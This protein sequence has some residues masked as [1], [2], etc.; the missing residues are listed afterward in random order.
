MKI[1]ILVLTINSVVI[2]QSLI[3]PSLSA[4]KINDIHFVNDNEIILINSG[5]SIYKSYNGGNSWELKSHFQGESLI[6]IEF[7]NENTGFILP[8]K[9]PNIEAIGI[10]YTADAGDNWE[11]QPLDVSGIYDFIPLSESVSLKST[12]NGQIERLN[13]F[14]NKWD[15]VYSLP[16]F[17]VEDPEFGEYKV[18]YGEIIKF[19]KI[20]Q[21]EII[22]LGRNSNAFENEILFDSLSFL[23]RSNDTGLSWDTVWIGFDFF[24]H[25]LTFSNSTTGWMYNNESIFKSENGGLTWTKVYSDANLG[26]IEN[27]YSVNENVIYATLD[28]G[29]TIIKTNNSGNN[30]EQVNYDHNV[31][32]GIIFYNEYMGFL[33][34]QKLIKTIDGCST[35][36]KLHDPIDDNLTDIK[37]INKNIGFAGGENGIY[38]SVDGGISWE[39]KL[40]VP[41]SNS[42][43][44]ALSK[45]ENIWYVK[46]NSIYKS[47]DLGETWQNTVLSANSQLYGG[48]SFYDDNLGIIYSVAEENIPGSDIYSTKY[49]YITVD[50]GINWKPILVDSVF[51]D[52]PFHKVKFTDPEHLFAIG[53]NGLWVSK[54]S[55]KTWHSIYSVDYFYT[56]YSFDFYDSITGILSFGYTKSLFTID[57]GQTWKEFEKPKGISINDCVIIGPSYDNEVIRVLEA[58]DNGILNYYYFNIDG[59]VTYSKQLASFTNSSLNKIEVNIEEQFPNIWIGSNNFN[60]IYREYEKLPT[61][62]K[63]I[64]NQILDKFSLSQNYPNPFNPVTT[65]G[66]TIPTDMRYEYQDVRLVIYDI[67]GREVAILVNQRQKPGNYIVNFD[68]ASL[69]SGIYYYQLKTDSFVQTKKMILLK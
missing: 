46:F 17:S 54:D 37:F 51:S 9:K 61:D 11:V 2:S 21:N 60:I 24:I 23:L 8:E 13:N 4:D 55:S 28:N 31:G 65:I 44:L 18:S 27:L 59:E 19:E 16:T 12:W 41:N 35:F 3:Y 1:V 56:G 47:I 14:Y 33:F 38:K 57:G 40:F 5:G 49:N 29:K 67:L 48:I 66:Y 45:N 32:S 64:D 69:S 58:G 52:I 68:A 39:Q 43:M 50:G 36:E 10:I 34:G 53:R 30:W 15:T 7:I 25:N 26:G 62:L 20:S 6:S 22:A 63:E 42:G